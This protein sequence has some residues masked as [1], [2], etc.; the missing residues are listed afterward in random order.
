MLCGE[1]SLLCDKHIL[2]TRDIG[3]GK[4]KEIALFQHSKYSTLIYLHR[5]IHLRPTYIYV[6][7]KNFLHI[8]V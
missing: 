7:V 1:L 4:E 8:Y 6:Y 2:F 3:I 5:H